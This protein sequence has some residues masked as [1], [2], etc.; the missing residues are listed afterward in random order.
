MFS[1]YNQIYNLLNDANIPNTKLYLKEDMPDRWRL[2]NHYR[3]AP[4]VM[5]A[6]I[7]YDLAYVSNFT[8]SKS[9]IQN[10]EIGGGGGAQQFV[11]HHVIKYKYR[12]QTMI[13]LSS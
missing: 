3:V 13:F 8:I 10:I 2:K 9:R 1:F 12:W 4:I 11:R 7:G 5:T 6:D